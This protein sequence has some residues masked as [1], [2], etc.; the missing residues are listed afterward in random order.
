MGNKYILFLFVLIFLFGCG[1]SADLEKQITGSWKMEKVYEFGKDVSQKHNP[2]NNRWIEFEEDGTF[3]SDG[4]PF[5]KNT[6]RWKIDNSKSV[7]FIDSD[8]DDDDS[9]W[10]LTFDG[11][12]MI[13]TGIGQSRKENTKLIHKRIAK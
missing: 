2:D 1:S 10:N 11:D 4:D 8:V 3:V 13:W 12:K 7:L 5:G 9:Q 6:G